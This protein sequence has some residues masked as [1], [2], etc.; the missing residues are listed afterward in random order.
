MVSKLVVGPINKGLRTDRLP[1]VIDNDSFPT[2][3]NAYQWRGRVKRKRGTRELGRLNRNIGTTNG[4]GNLVV[5]ITP[6]PI[7]TGISSFK[8]GSD[9]FVDPGTTS[10]PATQTLLTNSS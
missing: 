8:I 7:A 1:F 3:V 5:S 10:N 4:S 9:V 2:L 6:I